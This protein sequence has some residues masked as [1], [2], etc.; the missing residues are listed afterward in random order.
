MTLLGKAPKAAAPTPAKRSYKDGRLFVYYFNNHFAKYPPWPESIIIWH[1]W[2]EPLA[3]GQPKFGKV[4]IT[5]PVILD[6]ERH[7]SKNF[8]STQGK[9]T[10]GP[11]YK[12]NFTLLL[13]VAWLINHMLI[14]VWYESTYPSP[15]FNGCTTELWECISNFTPHL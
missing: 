15:N 8:S 10:T 4:S 14:K 3:Y 12:H 9:C 13:Y 11:F 5:Q 1:A 6:F 7:F 2:C